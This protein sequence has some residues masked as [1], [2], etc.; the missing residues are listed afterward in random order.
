[1][2][3]AAF[4]NATLLAAAATAGGRAALSEAQAAAT[5]T[6]GVQTAGSIPTQVTA[7]PLPETLASTGRTF[8]LLDVAQVLRHTQVIRAQRFAAEAL[9][10]DALAHGEIESAVA[11]AASGRGE[12]STADPLHYMSA[13]IFAKTLSEMVDLANQ[14]S[15][16]PISPEDVQVALAELYPTRESLTAQIQSTGAV[17]VWATTHSQRLGPV[18]QEVGQRILAL[19]KELADLLSPSKGQSIGVSLLDH[20][21]KLFGEDVPSVMRWYYR[22]VY[23]SG[24]MTPDQFR[25]WSAT[26]IANLL[27]LNRPTGS[28]FRRAV[29][30]VPLGTRAK[31]VRWFPWPKKEQR[32]VLGQRIAT[33]D[34]ELKDVTVKGAPDV[35]IETRMIITISDPQAFSILAPKIEA[36]KAA[37]PDI[38]LE[39]QLHFDPRAV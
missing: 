39:V 16:L 4:V 36:W 17:V 31:T 15:R 24:T 33:L 19:A 35:Q 22:R 8:S 32:V 13:A 28:T 20:N 38:S 21:D 9:A 23:E 10:A 29:E 25:S 1:M 34:V 30:I 2:I 11:T 27:C 6:A 37:N 14:R 3:L 7:I 26:G 18:V 12:A 5:T